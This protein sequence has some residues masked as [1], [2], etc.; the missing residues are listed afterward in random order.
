MNI[1]RS[2]IGTLNEI[3]FEKK[4]RS[5]GAYAIRAA[6]GS[7]VF[8]SLGIT[9]SLIIGTAWL[10][11]IW[12]AKEVE[13]RIPVAG[14]PPTTTYSVDFTPPEPQVK[15]KTDPPG[16][17]PP[18]RAEAVL[19]RY[20]VRDNATDSTAVVND[21][22][23]TVG[24]TTTAGTSTASVVSTST[25]SGTNTL[26]TGDASNS[27]PFIIYDEAPV[28]PGGL[29]QFWAKNLRYPREAREAG[30]QG[31]LAVNFVLDENGKVISCKVIRKLGYGCDEEVL[32]VIKLMPNWQ[33]AKMNGQPIKISFNQVVEFHL[34]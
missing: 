14:D 22:L 12:M 24:T 26:T 23:V 9:S 34:R 15:P 17:Q 29:P 3:L 33:P 1:F 32:R 18:Q 11:S 16:G 27:A 6:Y 19:N 21:P 31:K 2:K 13:V 8:K 4:N 28:F 5:Y 10:L 25:V 20:E 30:V 7:T